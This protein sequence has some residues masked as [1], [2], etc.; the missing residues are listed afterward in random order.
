DC[1]G[2]AATTSDRTALA[3]ATLT[4]KQGAST[5]ATA[6]SDASGNYN[7]GFLESGTYDVLVTAP[8]SGVAV[9]AVPGSG[10]TSQTRISATDVQVNL[11]NAQTSGTNLF[12][13]TTNHSAP[14]TI[15]VVPGSKATGDPAF[16]MA[17]NGTGFARCAVVRLN[18]SPRTTTWNSATS[19]TAAIPASDMFTPGTKTITVFNATPGGGTSNS[20]N[21][22]V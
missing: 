10:G 21:F 14:S 22:V 8:A 5:L 12:L 2:V 7:F 13:V 11:T 4:L 3:G 1:D 6:T 17:V 19:L 18:G 20:Q 15:N 16:N 9:D